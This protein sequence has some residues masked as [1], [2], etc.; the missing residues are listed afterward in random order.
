M[1]NV[2]LQAADAFLVLNKVRPHPLLENG[3]NPTSEVFNTEGVVF[4]KNKKHLVIAPSGKGKSTF[5]HAAYGLRTDFD[6]DIFLENQ[7]VRTFD[8][9]DWAAIRQR[10]LAIVFQDLR[11]FLNL[12]AR[13]NID[14]KRQLVLS[15]KATPSVKTVENWTK[16]LGIADFLEKKC[17]T[18]SYG[19]RQRVAIL[20]TLCQPFDMLLL[21]EPFSHLDLENQKIASEIIVEAC[22]QN[23]NAGFIIVSLGDEGFFK[24]DKKWIL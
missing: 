21:D 16:R 20:R 7:N 24:Y 9:G 2:N 8:V 22:E 23:D 3:L 10:R 4:E 17:D 19:Q 6:G 13:E 11:L 15:E 12:T 18:L 5:I 14:L 1:E